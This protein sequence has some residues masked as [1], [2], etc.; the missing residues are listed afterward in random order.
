MY[1][2]ASFSPLWLLK[3]GPWASDDS[4]HRVP[5]LTSGKEETTSLL[6][7]QWVISYWPILA[8]AGAHTYEDVCFVHPPRNERSMVK[9]LVQAPCTGPRW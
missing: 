9:K 5:V 6:H 4:V 7:E 3:L 2:H 1:S 8:A